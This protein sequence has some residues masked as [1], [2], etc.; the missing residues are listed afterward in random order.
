MAVA[1]IFTTTSPC[2]T[3]SGSGTVSTLSLRVPCQVTALIGASSFL[4][5][6]THVRRIFPA[7]RGGG[8][9]SR[10]HQ[11]LEL[12]QVLAHLAVGVLAEQ[13]RHERAE[14]SARRLVV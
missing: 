2:C 13:P 12:P 14:L 9:R 5:R 3:I 6:G 8:D 7:S 10:L 1:L 4:R 11:L